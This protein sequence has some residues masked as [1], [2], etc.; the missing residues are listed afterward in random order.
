MALNITHAEHGVFALVMQGA[1]VAIGQALGAPYPWWAGA[2]FAIAWFVSREHTQREYKL[3]VFGNRPK[4]SPLEGF[5]GWSVDAWL[6][7]IVPAVA[8]AIAG[9]GYQWWLG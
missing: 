1:F 2:A 9:F 7:A 3:F 4:L 6:D 5:K 8:V